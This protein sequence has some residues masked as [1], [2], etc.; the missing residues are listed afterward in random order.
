[1]LKP[2]LVIQN[3]TFQLACVLGRVLYTQACSQ[4]A[5]GRGNFL[6]RNI[7]LYVFFNLE[8]STLCR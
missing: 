8:H 3:S 5:N 1:M 4:T 7:I 2:T 6:S